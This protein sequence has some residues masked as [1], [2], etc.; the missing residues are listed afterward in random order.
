[1]ITA[2]V[3]EKTGGAIDRSDPQGRLRLL[4]KNADIYRD[5]VHR[6][7]ETNHMLRIQDSLFG[8]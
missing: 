3:N 6:F 7:R 5:L 2:G 1:M 4:D 8:A